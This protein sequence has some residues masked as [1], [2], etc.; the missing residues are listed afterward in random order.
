[1]PE[2]SICSNLVPHQVQIFANCCHIRQQHCRR[3][4]R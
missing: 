2:F 3:L 4:L 1:M